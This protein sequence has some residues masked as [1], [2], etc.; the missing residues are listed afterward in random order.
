MGRYI[1][2]I[3]QIKPINNLNFPLADVN[4]LKGGYIQLE[5]LAERED[6][7]SEKLRPGMLCFILE[8]KKIYQYLDNKWSEFKTASNTIINTGGGGVSVVETADDLNQI[9]G[10][11]AIA[12]IIDEDKL[13][14]YNGALWNP[15]NRIYI[16]DT[17][18]EDKKGIWIDTSSKNITTENDVISSLLKTVSILQREV[19]RLSYLVNDQLDFGSVTKTTERFTGSGIAPINDDEGLEPDDTLI[20]GAL[21]MKRGTYAEVYA[22]KDLILH[23][24]LV[25]CY[26]IDALLTKSPLT[27]ELVLL[28]TGSGELPDVPD[29][30]NTP[31]DEEMEG[32]LTEIIGNKTKIVGIEM[33]DIDGSN[34]FTISVDANGLKVRNKKLD[35]NLLQAISQTAG[36]NGNSDYYKT[37]YF[38]INK[39]Y[40]N[41][42]NPQIYVN[43][44]YC[45]EDN[46]EYDYCPVSHNFVELANLTTKDLNLCG[47]YLHYTNDSSGDWVTLPLTGVIKSGSTFLIRGAQ[48]AVRNVNT[49]IIDVEEPDLYWDK[50]STYQAEILD[51]D[52]KS[53]WDDNDLIKF[54]RNCSFFLSG[55]PSGVSFKNDGLKTTAP[56]LNAEVILGYVDLVGFGTFPDDKKAPNESAVFNTLG[57]KYLQCRYY[58]LDPV[59]QATKALSARKNS[60]EW[61]AVDLTTNKI[62]AKYAP[63][64]SRSNKTVFFNKELLQEGAPNIITCTFGYDAHK[65][66]CFTWV[67]VGYYDEYLKYW[68]KNDTTVTTIESFKEG[69]GR[70]A[71]NNRDNAIY[72]RIRNITTDGTAFTSHK[73]IVD[74]PEVSSDT[75]YCYQVGREGAWSEVR[76]FTLRNRSKVI[77]NGF[78]FLQFSDQQGF[79]TEEYD[80]MYY[81]NEMINNDTSNPFD[82]VLNVGDITQNGNRVNEWVSYFKNSEMIFKTREQMFSIGNNDLCPVDV[83]EL[84]RGAE[85]DKI[86]PINA[87]YFFTFE[88]PNEIPTSVAGNYIPCVYDFI[89]GDTYFLSMNSELTETACTKLY[90]DTT[91]E[92]T[93]KNLE[94]WCKNS[95]VK[96]NE[97]SQLQWRVAFCHEAP[98]TILT[99]QV[100][101]DFSKD[102]SQTRDGSHVNT[103]GGYFFSKFLQ[104][105]DF[106]LC[107]CGHKHTYSNSR[108]IHD[109][110]SYDEASGKW[111]NTMTPT[112]YD[113]AGESA[114]WYT[115]LPALAKPCVKVS[116]DKT[117]KYVKYA[118][119]QACGFKLTSNKELPAWN[120]P[121]L[122]GYYPVK[123]QVINE[124]GEAT[125]TVNPD[126]Q[127]PNYIIWKIG[128]GTELEDPSQTTTS[129]KR[130]CGKSLKI[131][132]KSNG[133][134]T[135][136]AWKYLTPAGI[137]DLQIVG[138]NG[139]LNKD[140]GCWSNADD[141]IIV[142][143]TL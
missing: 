116:T 5:T 93:Y 62:A 74:F 106:K 112:V 22:K 97:D 132:K 24:E 20:A 133:S 143:Q 64:A 135:W 55:Q 139:L 115:S 67:S 45:G 142:E 36:T 4:D 34:N 122:L 100:M 40:A 77:A 7:N 72:N 126:Q 53:I 109:N 35:T 82:F 138:G 48:C 6:I 101:Q 118:M 127:Y 14:F 137:N 49:T 3:S 9:E 59:S 18:P 63:K 90:G 54:S 57:E 102:S 95:L 76:E 28:G 103:V 19:E 29:L 50:A 46:G 128:S 47:L 87:N 98:F 96:A 8:T 107:M 108:L 56:Y 94:T 114:E 33:S 86:N 26:D 125:V 44:V 80:M 60:T 70:E 78:K 83:H 130:I 11:G 58:N 123:T 110:A 141:Y 120:I 121:W 30:P 37:L 17:E 88:H 31:T 92:A 15:T 124:K 38:P 66:R 61:S 104:E 69:D 13:V 52:S 134:G 99:A 27:D 41:S 43:S 131:T 105:N 16:Q 71:I 75:V 21:C 91:G 25:Y 84:G 89:Y 73:V 111:I 32:I 136:P 113:P 129:R 1:E 42:D 10:V 2:V 12:Y 81:C 68:K 23:G 140:R 79:T 39:D 85:P 51:T 65:T 117:L 119:T